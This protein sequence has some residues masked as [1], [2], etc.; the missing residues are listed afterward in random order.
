[1]ALPPPETRI[2]ACSAFIEGRRGGPSSLATAYNNRGIAY[3]A[4]ADYDRAVADFESAIAIDPAFVKP[5]NNRGA[6]RLKK[7]E[8]DAAIEDFDR[9]IGLQ[10]AYAGAFANRAEAW[11]KKGDYARA[12]SDYAAATRLSADMEGAWS[13]LCW[14]RAVDGDP[15]AAME[16]CDKAIGAGRAYGPTHD[17]RARPSEVWT[18]RR[19]DRRLRCRAAHRPEA[20]ERAVRQRTCEAP[21][22]QDV[23]G[24]GGHR[25]REGPPD[26][27]RRGIRALRRAVGVA[28]RSHR[29][30]PRPESCSAQAGRRH[31]DRC[32][33]RA[34]SRG[35]RSLF[36][37]AR[38]A[39][40]GYFCR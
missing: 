6:T 11:L 9:A 20:R 15:Q 12:E 13:G 18:P 25:G 21:A 16:A 10:P 36:A 8:Y 31:A 5:L 34:R 14:I 19:R 26:R 37:L 29:S 35:C 38:R 32:C 23:L 2:E 39:G 4:K 7:G 1:M 22:R 33:R 40:S 3:A 17:S 28:I 30:R 27:Y 24:R